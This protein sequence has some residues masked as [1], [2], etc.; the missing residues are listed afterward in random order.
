MARAIH[1][2]SAELKRRR[3]EEHD[4]KPNRCK[5]CDKPLSYEER[6]KK[7]CDTS[8]AASANNKRRKR[9]VVR[10][11]RECGK[12]FNLRIPS[13][14]E[15]FCSI[16]CSGSHRKRKVVE[17]WL[18]TGILPMSASGQPAARSIKEYL[19]GEQKSCCAVCESPAEHNGK[20][21]T[22]ILDHIDGDSTN[23]ERSNLR[24]VC[25]NCD[26]QLNTYKARNK[27]KGRRS[28]GF[29]ANAGL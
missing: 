7:Y 23:N 27:G 29:S 28:R 13:A 15:I 1:N 2:G 9:V 20:S 18:G 10:E 11:C 12:E 25:P 6:H 14:P 22:L 24:C 21:L 26:S 5:Y 8:C 16:S 4:K 19:I 3:V 17:R